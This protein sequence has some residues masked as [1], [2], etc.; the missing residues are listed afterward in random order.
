[1]SSTQQRLV[2]VPAV[3]S[4]GTKT[5][6]FGTPS[7][8]ENHDSSDFYERFESVL[9][10]SMGVDLK[11]ESGVIDVYEGESAITLGD[12][13]SLALP[14][15][16]VAL[17]VT[18][19]PYFV[20][21]DY[22]LDE[23][24]PQSWGEY[25]E[26][27]VEVWAEAFRVLEPGGRIAVNVAGLGR[28][29]YR[30][31]PGI[32]ADQLTSAGFMLRGEIVWLKAAGSNS[33]ATG[34]WSSPHNPVM[35]DLS[36]RVVV[37]SKG[38]MSRLGS[39]AERQQAGLPYVSDLNS[40][41]WCRDTIDVWRIAPALATRVGHPAPFPVELAER[42]I[43]LHTYEDDLVVDPMCGS[44]TSCLAAAN[45]HRRYFGVDKERRYVDLA[46]GRLGAVQSG[47]PFDRFGVDE[48]VPPWDLE[49][50]DHDL[51]GIA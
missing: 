21:K 23:D 31:L 5:A 39:Q 46:R 32:V 13:R 41:I 16:S 2:K 50:V 48:I 26:L 19:P 8:R 12:A 33:M 40:E 7:G 35:R 22:E 45:L 17:V 4:R 51:N 42:L 47:F 36:E 49:G 28:K 30:H 37:A 18:S 43:R 20:G 29:P 14:D 10:P 9:H 6:S 1:M 15:N 34:T 3:R 24:S 44:G 27:L 11:P 25:L 38:Q